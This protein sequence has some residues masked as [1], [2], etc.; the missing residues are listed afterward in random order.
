VQALSIQCRT[1]HARARRKCLRHAISQDRASL[2]IPVR[3]DAERQNIMISR[4]QRLL[5]G[6]LLLCAG[7]HHIRRR[8]NARHPRRASIRRVR[9]CFSTVVC[10]LSE[11]EFRRVFRM[12][13]STFT[14]LLNVLLPDLLRDDS[15]AL[16]SSGG[17]IEPEIRLA[18]TLRLLAGVLPGHLDAFRHKSVFMQSFMRE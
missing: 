18:L 3:R 9:P 4:Q 5:C 15:M 10:D 16:R 8:D 6:L 1:P 12:Q 7:L 2:T 17:R 11:G 14:S 13:R